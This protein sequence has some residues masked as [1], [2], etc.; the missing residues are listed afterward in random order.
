MTS[1]QSLKERFPVLEIDSRILAGYVLGGV[2]FFLCLIAAA[3]V[4]P[5]RWLQI[6]L[7]L[8]GGVVGWV[9]GIGSTPL[10]EKEGELFTD[11]AKAASAFVS[12][13]VIAKLGVI[14]DALADKVKGTGGE[15]LLFRTLLF[16]TCLLLGF[17][18]TV[19]NRLYLQW[20]YL[21][22]SNKT[23]VTG[24]AEDSSQQ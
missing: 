9:I 12:G 24:Q 23:P 1:W 22:D 17:L 21:K 2:A 8:F 3:I 6:V 13:F 5:D 15:V 10:D 14:G 20:L 7:C 4:P 16:G 11:F 18:F 19:I